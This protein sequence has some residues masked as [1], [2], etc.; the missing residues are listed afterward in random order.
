MDTRV[1]A[2]GAVTSA[3]PQ[4]GGKHYHVACAHACA[5]H[6]PLSAAH[7][8]HLLPA[9]KEYDTVAHERD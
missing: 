7:R 4:P 2:V 9:P 6:F 1:Q 3:P 5:Y 8:W